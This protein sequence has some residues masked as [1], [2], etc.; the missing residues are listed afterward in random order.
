MV[1]FGLQSTLFDFVTFGV[2]L[3]VLGST[4][5]Q[6]R[7]GWFTFSIATEIIVMLVIRT[8]RFFLRSRPSKYLLLSSAIMLAVVIVLPYS[9]I[10]E[11]LGL[12]I[13]PVWNNISLIG[14]IVA[15]IITAE[16]TKLLF[17]RKDMAK[18]SMQ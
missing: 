18:P 4:V 9:P 2:L 15:Y 11:L 6:F 14:L 3:L 16:M 10:A 8:R 1:V 13:L 5:D 7:T 17:Y 12:V